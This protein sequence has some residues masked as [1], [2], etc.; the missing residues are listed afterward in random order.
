MED[1]LLCFFPPATAHLAAL[2]C[3]N[4]QQKGTIIM[5][6]ILAQRDITYLIQ[7]GVSLKNTAHSVFQ[8]HT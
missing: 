4:K 7:K 1:Y 5:Q 3:D 6:T 8:V 2:S